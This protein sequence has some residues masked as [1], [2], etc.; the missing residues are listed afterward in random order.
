MIQYLK[1]DATAPQA[2]GPKLIVH[3]VNTL[4]GWGS[5][6]VLAI[7][8]RW[9]EPEAAYRKWYKDKS[10]GNPP[11][12]FELGAIQLVQVKLDTTV[13]NMVA[14]QGIGTGSNGPPIRYDALEK[15][16][17]SVAEWAQKSGAS[18]HAPRIGCALAGGRWREVEPI[19]QRTLIKNEVSVTIYDF[20]PFNP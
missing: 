11:V 15:C 18:V 13:V 4:G 2:K 9:S 16:L 6:F 5:G 17:A 10:Y 1:G 8:K 3:I 20:G 7:S 19:L 14:Q 12:K